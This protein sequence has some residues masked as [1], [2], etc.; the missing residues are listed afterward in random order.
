MTFLG[1][2]LKVLTFKVKILSFKGK[3]LG[4]KGQNFK[5]QGL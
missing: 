3:I 4:H 1:K 2:F 5:L